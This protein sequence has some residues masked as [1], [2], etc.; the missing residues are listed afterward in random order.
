M[1]QYYY[2]RIQQWLNERQ[3]LLQAGRLLQQYN[4]DG[5]MVIEEE[6]FWYIQN[7]QPKL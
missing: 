4:V 5:Y 6:R 3:T 2:F 7:N 1:S